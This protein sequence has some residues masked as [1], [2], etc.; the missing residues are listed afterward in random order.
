LAVSRAIVCVPFGGMIG[1][2]LAAEI[3]LTQ[4][5]RTLFCWPALRRSP[6]PW[7]SAPVGTIGGVNSITCATHQWLNIISTAG[8]L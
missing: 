2:L 1:G 4:G 6:S 7:T 8:A 3:L 5:W